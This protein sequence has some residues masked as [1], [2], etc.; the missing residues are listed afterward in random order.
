[1]AGW[2]VAALGL[3]MPPRWAAALN[4]KPGR[5]REAKSRME[6]NL[7]E[8]LDMSPLGPRKISRGPLPFS[9]EPD[10]RIIAPV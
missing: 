9:S 1:M 2:I 4:D 8:S 5:H 7:G 3:R 6:A 10:R